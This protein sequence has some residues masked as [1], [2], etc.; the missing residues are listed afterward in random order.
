MTVDEVNTVMSEADCL[1]S[2]AQVD[3][4]LDT[5]A[6]AISAELQDKNPLVLCVMT[7][8]MIPAGHLLTRLDFPLQVDYIHASRYSGETRGGDLCWQ[9]KPNFPLAGRDILIIDDILDEGITLA[10]IVEYCRDEGATSVCT[11]VLVE[12]KHD[13]KNGIDADFVG[14]V[15]EDRYLFGYGMDYK[16]YLRNAAGIYAVKGL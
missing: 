3:A 14:L 15:T 11:A 10:A 6:A 7:G 9:T 1:Y 8:A 4:A 12:K 5:M 13:R 16:D 2:A